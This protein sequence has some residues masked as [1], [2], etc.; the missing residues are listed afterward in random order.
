M[1]EDHARV[2][3]LLRVGDHVLAQCRDPATGVDQDR[4]R[5]LVREREQLRHVRMGERELLGTRVQLD[6][7]GAARERALG[8]GQRAVAGLHATERHEQPV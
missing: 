2:G 5:A 6:A 3:I 7:L 1:G 8:L 4:E